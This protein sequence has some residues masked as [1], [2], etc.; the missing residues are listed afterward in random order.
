MAREA[1]WWNE[2]NVQ[3]VKRP[4][5]TAPP[6]RDRQ[7]KALQD[8]AAN[9]KSCLRVPKR[10]AN[11]MQAMYTVAKRHHLQLHSESNGQF[12]YYWATARK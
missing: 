6:L 2:R 9:P 4:A 5:P 7:L 10:Y 12:V 3:V 8:T 11:R 1:T